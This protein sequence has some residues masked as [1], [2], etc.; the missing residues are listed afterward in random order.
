MDI[1][2]SL[3]SVDLARQLFVDSLSFSGLRWVMVD[4]A[5]GKKKLPPHSLEDKR[6]LGS[7]IAQARRAAG[8]TIDT[9]AAALHLVKQT[10]SARE[11]GR[12]LPDAL[13]LRR[14]ARLYDTSLDALV[15]TEQEVVWPFST[16]LHE[17]VLRLS[18]EAVARLEGVM[19]AHLDLPQVSLSSVGNKPQLVTPSRS[20][21]TYPPAPEEGVGMP[22]EFEVPAPNMDD[23][24]TKARRPAH[25]KGGRGT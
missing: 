21:A 7:H 4:L 2:M 23:R 1:A 6:A 14:L 15:G 10:I 8:H 5:E 12:N 22:P 24:S 9:A 25:H 11:N 19:R 20:T 3:C 16:E 17:K 13:Q 18:P